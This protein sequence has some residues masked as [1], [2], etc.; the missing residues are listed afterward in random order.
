MKRALVLLLLLAAVGHSPPAAAAVTTTLVTT[1][2]TP[3]F[4]THARDRRLFIVE[5][6]G[7]IRIYDRNTRTLLAT[8][9]L[10]IAAKV[11][12]GDER[13]LFSVAF[14]PDYAGN[15]FFYV[16]YT[17]T[18]G[19]TMI[20]RYRVSGNPNLAD[21]A[22]A[23]TLMNIA[24]PFA[25]HNGGQ[26]QVG[27]NDGYLYIGM[28]DGGSGGDPSCFAQRT[29]S[30]LGK[31]LRL[32]IRKNLNTP[33]FYGIP[34]DNPYAGP[35]DPGGTIPDEIWAL[36]LRNPWRFSFDRGSG[37]L[38]LGDVGQ[39]G[40]EEIDVQR[41]GT[42]GGANF[43]WKVME[44]SSCY[45]TDACPPGTPPCGSAPLTAPIHTYPT[46]DGC[47]VIGGYFYRGRLM[48][49]ATGRYLFG[50]YCN[51]QIAT[52]TQSGSSWVRQPLLAVGGTLA[53]F[54]EDSDGELYVA[55]DNSVFALVGSPAAVPAV[56]LTGVAALALALA[57]ALL[58]AHLRRITRPGS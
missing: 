44:G 33:P 16:D 32:D 26:L 23:V 55:V 40:F 6:A 12:T 4:V 14:H 13:G 47:A 28:G 56:S 30:L 15:G 58:G 49:E 10:D 46:A 54:G 20:E 7:R 21:P 53:S 24:Q 48:G 3:V 19:N 5:L 38:Y 45:S 27:P 9:F 18:S 51:G 41:A 11:S 31:M 37:D 35:K 36:G 1:V 52:L 22:S 39:S 8:P 34:T 57:L 2:A 50:D 42:P 25:N 17:D 43:G 29:D